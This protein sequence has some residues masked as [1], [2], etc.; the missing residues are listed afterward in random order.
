ALKGLLSKVC[1]EGNKKYKL[2]SISDATGDAKERKTSAVLTFPDEGKTY[3]H[4]AEG[5]NASTIMVIRQALKD[6]FKLPEDDIL[7]A[8]KQG[9]L[10][11]LHKMQPFSAL[12]A[13]CTASQYTVSSVDF[14]DVVDEKLPAFICHITVK[15]FDGVEIQTKGPQAKSKALAKE[16]AAALT[17]AQV[18]QIDQASLDEAAKELQ[19][20][21]SATAVSKLFEV[22]TK[23]KPAIR[24]EFT[25][26]GEEV[27]GNVK[28]Y[29][30]KCVVGGSE[31]LGRGQSKKDAKNEAA[32]EALN[33]IS[34]KK[35]PAQ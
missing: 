3:A 17:L 11:K 1:L 35:I 5:I 10:Q 21:L 9:Q 13:M 30:F 27:D 19:K 4:T 18:F 14:E 24:P 7:N 32:I 8:I 28:Y 20:N 16:K 15:N 2:D 33:S 31:F 25:D 23:Q 26:M 22:G 6:V 29:K 12:L 34:A